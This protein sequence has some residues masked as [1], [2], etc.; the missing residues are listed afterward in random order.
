MGGCV[1]GQGYGE[2][3]AQVSDFNFFS[4]R[5]LI[6]SFRERKLDRLKALLEGGLSQPGK[7]SECWFEKC[8]AEEKYAE[9]VNLQGSSF[10][11]VRTSE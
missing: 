1:D 10:K 9:I 5:I 4:Y 2:G 8:C 7:A 6:G 3:T 11:H